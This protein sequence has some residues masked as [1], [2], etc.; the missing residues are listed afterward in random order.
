M[1]KHLLMHIYAI[2]TPAQK[3]KQKRLSTSGLCYWKYTFQ[4]SPLFLDLQFVSVRGKVICHSVKLQSCPALSLISWCNIN[5][6]IRSDL[7][8]IFVCS[9][10]SYRKSL[11]KR[12][13][14][15]TINNILLKI[16][17]KS[18][19]RQL[20]QIRCY[21]QAQKVV[22]L[23]IAAKLQKRQEFH[24]HHLVSVDEMYQIHVNRYFEC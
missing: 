4:T 13:W 16:G 17:M 22:A 8:Y 12:E 24:I 19:F 2:I 23:L 7:F 10:V 6:A 20:W 11:S 21:V 18:S 1:F 9:C 14:V 3:T 5:L 15:D